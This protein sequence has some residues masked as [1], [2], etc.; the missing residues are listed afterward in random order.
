M[1]ARRPP[2]AETRET[3]GQFT[4]Q[5]TQQHQANA[6]RRPPKGTDGRSAVEEGAGPP[7][8]LGRGGTFDPADRACPVY[9]LPGA[10]PTRGTVGGFCNTTM[11]PQGM[12][13][14]LSPKGISTPFGVSVR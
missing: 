12:S 13:S 9:P 5:R 4:D 10:Q 8:V 14:M 7:E 3:A 1:L 2:A 11:C 6:T